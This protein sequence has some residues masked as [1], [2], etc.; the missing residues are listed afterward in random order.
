MEDRYKLHND[1]VEYG[2]L[3]CFILNCVD[4]SQ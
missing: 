3:E 1:H 2:E 4:I